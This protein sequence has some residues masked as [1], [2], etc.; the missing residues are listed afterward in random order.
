MVSARFPERAHASASS[1]LRA[2]RCWAWA[3][4]LRGAQMT[5]GGPRGWTVRGLRRRDAVQARATSW[6]DAGARME[7][8]ER[9]T[10]RAGQYR[11]SSEGRSTWLSWA[12]VADRNHGKSAN[13]RRSSYSSTSSQRPCGEMF[14]TS[15]AKVALPGILNLLDVL[16]NEFH[17]LHQ[18]S[19]REPRGGREVD[20]W[21]QPELR[22]PIR[23]CHVHEDARPRDP[24]RRIVGEFDWL[25]ATTSLGL[26]QRRPSAKD[27]CGPKALPGGC[28]PSREPSLVL[29]TEATIAASSESSSGVRVF[30][31]NPPR[32]S[33]ATWPQ[34][35]RGGTGGP[36]SGRG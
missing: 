17:G 24:S 36:P 5:P 23:M 30:G 22:L 29:R 32:R 9:S 14:V 3:R 12:T 20:L 26:P 31:R 7:A 2:P 13:G 1:W 18:L 33:L 35:A 6:K 15:A 11:W 10:S 4:G 21:R 19:V 8:T 16:L 28:V 27:S 34:A 25:P